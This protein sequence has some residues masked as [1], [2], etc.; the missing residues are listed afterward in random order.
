ME[1]LC[2]KINMPEEVTRILLALD[3]QMEEY[4]CLELLRQD[5]PFFSLKLVYEGLEEATHLSG[6]WLNGRKIR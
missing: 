5:A 3:G 6:A 2:R 1:Q 4:P